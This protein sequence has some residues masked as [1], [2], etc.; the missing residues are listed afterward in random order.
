M[1]AFILFILE[2]NYFFVLGSVVSKNSLRYVVEA[3]F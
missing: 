3:S 1:G 2:S